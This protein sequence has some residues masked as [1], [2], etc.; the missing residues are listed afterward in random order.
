MLGLKSAGLMWVDVKGYGSPFFRDPQDV[1]A[2][3]VLYVVFKWVKWWCCRAAISSRRIISGTRLSPYNV[4]S[5]PAWPYRFRMSCAFS[6]EERLNN[7]SSSS[8]K[9]SSLIFCTFHANSA[10]F[11]CPVSSLSS[12]P[13]LHMIASSFVPSPDFSCL[14]RHDPVPPAES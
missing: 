5:P 14:L 11:L 2:A 1:V 8:L 3:E 4:L 13:E 12:V 10:S 7:C 6:L 9:G